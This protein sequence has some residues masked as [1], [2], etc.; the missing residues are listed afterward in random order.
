MARERRRLWKLF[1]RRKV[2]IPATLP[3]IIE[4]D[5]ITGSRSIERLLISF[6]YLESIL[7][8][9]LGTSL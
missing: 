1:D 9:I 6:E 7:L 3:A 8:E 4:K 2:L 5:Q